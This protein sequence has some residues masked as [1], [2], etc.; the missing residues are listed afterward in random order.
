MD[1]NS[2]MTTIDNNLQ[3]NYCEK[4]DQPIICS[5]CGAIIGEGQDFC[6]KCGTPKVEDHKRICSKCGIELQE[7]QDF[8]PKCGT[9]YDPD[10]S[11]SEKADSKKKKG[12]KLAIIIPIIVVVLAAVGGSVWFFFFRGISVSEVAFSKDTLTITEGKTA[13]IVSTVTPDNATDKTLTWTSSN[14]SVAKVDETGIVTAVAEGVCTIT[15]TASNGISC[16][17]KVTV[18]KLGPDFNSLFKKYCK[19]RWA[20]VGDDGSFLSVDTNPFDIDDS[21]LAYPEAYYAIEKI[22][23]ALGLPSSLSYDMEHTTAS[24]GKQSE[25]FNDIGVTVMWTYHPDRGLEVIYKATN[26]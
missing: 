21:G 12:N 19:E 15:A 26:K 4:K 2:N 22:N 8:C 16:E 17:C 9:R 1:E 14:E 25:T 7:G 11:A 6:P 13:S 20:S 3:D 10:V 24:Q 18:E 5:K 23:D